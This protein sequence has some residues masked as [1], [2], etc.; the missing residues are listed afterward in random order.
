MK[1]IE[2]MVLF[3]LLLAAFGLEAAGA[4]LFVAPSNPIEATLAAYRDNPF[5]S[6]GV[7]PAAPAT[8][9]IFAKPDGSKY[10]VISGTTQGTVLIFDSTLTTVRRQYDLSQP[11]TAAAMSPDGRRLLV[12]AGQLHIFDTTT[13]NDD[14]IALNPPPDLGASPSDVAISFDSRRAFILSDA[15]ERLTMFDLATNQVIGTPVESPT[16]SGDLTGLGF[17]PNGLLYLS[18]VNRFYEFDGFTGALRGQIALSAL[19]DKPIFTRDGRYAF[20]PNKTPQTSAGYAMLVDLQN[21]SVVGTIPN[22]GANA[23]LALSQYTLVDDNTVYAISGNGN[24]LVKISLPSLQVQTSGFVF[25]SRSGLLALGASAELPSAQYLFAASSGTISRGVLANSATSDLPLAVQPGKLMVVPVPSMFAP[26]NFRKF[27]DQQ[28][29]LANATTQP[30]ILQVWDSNGLPV[31]NRAVQFSTNAAGVTIE[32]PATVTNLEGYAGTRI[33]VP[34]TPSTVTITAAVDGLAAPITFQVVVAGGGG[35]GGGATGG[36]SIYSGNGQLLPRGFRT[37]SPLMVVVKDANNQP[38]IDAT[39]SWTVNG[40]GMLAAA[41]DKGTV[42]GEKTG[43]SRTDTSGIAQMYYVGPSLINF[44]ASWVQSTVTASAPNLNSVDFTVTTYPT[45]L[46]GTPAKPTVQLL[47]PPPENR[48]ITGQ[49]GQTLSGAVQFQV[50]AISGFQTGQGIPGVGVEVSTGLDPQTGPTASC[51]GGA[52]LSNASGI[53]VCNVVFGAV[54]GGPVPMLV[55]V[56]G[57]A[58]EYLVNL[59]VTPG[60]PGLVQITAGNNQSGGPGQTLPVSL[61]AQISDG[62][63]HILA[64]VPVVWTVVVPGTVTLSNTSSVSDANGMVKATATLGSTPGQV[65]VRLTAGSAQA[66]FTL[67]VNVPLSAPKKISGDSQTAVINTPFAQPLVVEVDDENGSPVA[68]LQVGFSVTSGS[69]MLSAT[70]VAT[71]SHGR[72]SVTVTAGNTPG[73]VQVNVSVPG[74]GALTFT[75]TVVPPGPVVSAVGIVN[76]IS[77]DQGVT[78]GGIT[79]IY[80]AG[81]APGIQG[82]V[83]GTSFPVGALPTSLAGVQ[84]LFG[85]IPAPI[86]SV[87]NVNGQEFVVVQTPF[88]VAAPGAVDITVTVGEGSTVVHNVPV[89]AYQPGIFETGPVGGRYAILIKPD[90]TFVGPDNPAHRGE[91]LKMLCAGIGQTDPPLRTNSSGVSEQKVLAPLTVGINNAGVPVIAAGTLFGT[92]GIYV[93]TFDVPQSAPSGSHVGLVFAVSPAGGAPWTFSNNSSI[94]IQ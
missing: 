83:T 42:T 78:P 75:L 29:V 16:I 64:G 86:Y 58:A 80:G 59:T 27:N 30:L 46:D 89:K 25:A 34:A 72:A 69:A 38:I 74:Q 32:T 68:G 44:S 87:N 93:I 13:A 56:G 71:D 53:G 21:R 7:V 22:S 8:V 33:T 65:Q 92:V 12:L 52:A 61:T 84:V 40:D 55:R 73:P 11:A 54:T 26:V 37:P 9:A 20:L 43:T 4:N 15:S 79:A 50:T 88:E 47:A 28:T 31:F 18:G 3:V 10:Y 24:R 45:L 19:P 1:V 70:S 60:P 49:A 63:G 76:A 57:G 51:Q 90:G 5:Q 23:G 36:L 66:V 85:N 48:N 62:F 82:S 94:N 81:L 91:R 67:N 39:V 41:D 14:E 35:G 77:G 17:A 6:V 2:R